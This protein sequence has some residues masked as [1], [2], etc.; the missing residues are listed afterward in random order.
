[1]KENI[2]QIISNTLGLV[3]KTA[4]GILSAISLLKDYLDKQSHIKTY[5]F[6]T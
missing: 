1:M 6:K 2:A 3:K 4:A 5:F